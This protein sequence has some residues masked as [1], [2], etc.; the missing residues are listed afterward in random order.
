M[1][2]RVH[3]AAM[4]AV[5]AFGLPASLPFPGRLGCGLYV[6][7]AL[8]NVPVGSAGALT[9]LVPTNPELRGLRLGVQGLALN[10]ANELTLTQGVRLVFDV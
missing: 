3:G 4:P 6:D 1:T 5:L 9:L 2:L 7:P 10:A 8:C